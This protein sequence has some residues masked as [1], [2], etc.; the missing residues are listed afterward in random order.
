MRNWTGNEHRQY[1]WKIKNDDFRNEK[2]ENYSQC[3]ILFPNYP[4]SERG[5]HIFRYS[6]AQFCLAFILSQKA[7]RRLPVEWGNTS[8]K[9][10]IGKKKSKKQGVQHKGKERQPQNRKKVP[11][12]E[13]YE[14]TVSQ[15]S[16]PEA[17]I[18]SVTVFADGA[19]KRLDLDEVLRLGPQWW[20][21]GL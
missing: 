4:L 12:E 6:R 15:D 19:V 11:Q 18:P 3:R 21:W 20:D 7:I 16:Y 10:M 17:L 8:G 13:A 1:H 2:S 14:R 9:K 5:R